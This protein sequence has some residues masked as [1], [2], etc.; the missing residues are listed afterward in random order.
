MRVCADRGPLTQNT[1]MTI[2]AYRALLTLLCVGCRHQSLGAGQH[3]CT[4]LTYKRPC[5]ARQNQQVRRPV[6][7]HS[8]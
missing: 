8:Q 5:P 6:R 4:W 3:N 7:P 1:K 2:L